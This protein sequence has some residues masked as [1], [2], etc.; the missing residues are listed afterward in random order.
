MDFMWN[1]PRGFAICWCLTSFKIRW[2]GRVRL[3]NKWAL[4][5]EAFIRF[6]GPHPKTPFNYHHI[7]IEGE[8]SGIP[9]PHTRLTEGQFNVCCLYKESIY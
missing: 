6:D 4:G 7:N 1:I 2:D 9:D 3:Y 8:Y 5:K